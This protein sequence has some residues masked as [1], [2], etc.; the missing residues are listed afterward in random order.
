MSGGRGGNKLWHFDFG[1]P[2]RG[3]SLVC[4]ESVDWGAVA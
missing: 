2:Y 4:L 3:Q 1:D